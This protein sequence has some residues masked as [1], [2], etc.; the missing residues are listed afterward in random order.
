M[1]LKRA[2]VEELLKHD[3]LV[4]PE[5]V[6]YI[7]EKGGLNYIPSF[8]S[9]YAN[10]GF[11]TISSI[12]PPKPAVEIVEKQE[13][14]LK[15]ATEKS[16]LTRPEA[17]EHDWDF[18]VLIDPGYTQS[19]GKVDDFRALFLDR[20]KRL[21]KHIK[22]NFLIRGATEIKDITSGE[23]RVIGLVNDVRRTSKGSLTFELEDP[24]GKIKCLYR[25]EGFLLNDEV[26][27]IV[28]TYREGSDIVYVNE[29][30]RP[31]VRKARR[32]RRIAEPIGA[33]IISD[34]HIGSKMFLRKSWEKFINWLKSGKD[35]AEIVKY[36]IIDG[37]LVDGIGIYPNQEEELDIL[38]IYQQYEALANY[39]AELPD[40]IK[41]IITPGNHDLV[42][43]T[44]PQPP[45]PS[46]VQKLFNGNVE[47]LS[48][49]SVFSLH[50]YT[51][52]TYHGASINDLVELIPG[53]NYERIEDIMKYMLEM[54]HL[55]PNYGGKV[56][57]APLPRDFMAI[58]LVPDV[59]VTGHVHAFSYERYKDVHIINSSCWQAQTKYQKMMNF[60]PVPGKVALMNFQKDTVRILSF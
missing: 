35:G 56:P 53:M 54:R 51:F 6:D 29:I 59:F 49:P 8:I 33:A 30:V 37:D 55:G 39:L 23:I 48:N 26:V 15:K 19:S 40:Y 58:D 22:R 25:D 18:R 52:L 57:I 36:L 5:V 20:Y 3:I 27:G 21:S 2:I 41:V 43:N 34:V 12:A 28:G 17:Y 7:L 38:D 46:D 13:G 45:L 4:E 11:I 1:N 31:G 47:F 60:N 42:R 24:T 44:E 10:S 9:K 32:E 14:S 16:D 50:G